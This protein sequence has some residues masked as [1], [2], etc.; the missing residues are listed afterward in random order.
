MIA[1]RDA[2][3]RAR[4]FTE[5]AETAAVLASVMNRPSMIAEQLAGHRIEQDDRRQMRRQA[6]GGV[7]AEHADH[8]RTERGGFR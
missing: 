4:C 3:R 6:D 1:S 8:F 5:T 7:A 2:S